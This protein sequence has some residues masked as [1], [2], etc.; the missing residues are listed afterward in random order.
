[1]TLSESNKL[2]TNMKTVFQ[3]HTETALTKEPVKTQ[4]D[5]NNQL[6]LLR[7]LR[8]VLQFR[9]GKRRSEISCEPRL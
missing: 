7:E 9:P 3:G 4:T 1:M 8:E 5:G 6:P 2:Q